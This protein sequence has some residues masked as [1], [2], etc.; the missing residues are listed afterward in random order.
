MCK[1]HRIGP[2]LV[3]IHHILPGERS[4][5]IHGSKSTLVQLNR[6][7][8]DKYDYSTFLIATNAT[9]VVIGGIY[10]VPSCLGR[11]IKQFNEFMFN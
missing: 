7:K 6:I 3:E 10:D 11:L 1:Q 9:D 5:A 8:L 4:P 2:V